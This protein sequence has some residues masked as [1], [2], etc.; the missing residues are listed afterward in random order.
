TQPLT[1]RVWNCREDPGELTDPADVA[2]VDRVHGHHGPD[3]L[4][5]IAAFAHTS[6]GTE[7]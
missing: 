2:A 6:D 4:P 3:C 7:Y 1:E 5:A